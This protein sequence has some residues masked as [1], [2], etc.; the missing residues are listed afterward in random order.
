MK[1]FEQD[2]SRPWQRSEP[3]GLVRLKTLVRYIAISRTRAVVNLPKRIDEVHRLDFSTAERQF[4][5]AAKFQ[6]IGLLDQAISST[7]EET[8]TFNALQKLNTLR[9]IC[10]HGLLAQKDLPEGTRIISEGGTCV[11]DELS[12][13]NLFDDDDSGSE[14]SAFSD[15]IL[16]TTQSLFGDS[17]SSTSDGVQIDS[18]QRG[19]AL[20]DIDP[21]DHQD[22]SPEL[23]FTHNVSQYRTRSLQ[24]LASAKSMHS[25]QAIIESMSTKIKALM[26][27]LEDC[28]RVEKWSVFV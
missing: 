4:Y 11:W 16:N 25:D 22:S 8:T 10:N 14:F 20:G 23:M 28:Y 18:S 26:K 9:L 1:I 3:V 19:L 24:T 7:D 21:L 13:E 27:S 2:I 15:S 5:E 17:Q 12:A 6:A